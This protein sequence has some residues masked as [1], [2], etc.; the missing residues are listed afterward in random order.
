MEL[1]YQNLHIARFT[2]TLQ[3]E[4]PE[5]HVYSFSDEVDAEEAMAL[6]IAPDARTKMVL[7]RSL[8]RAEALQE[9]ETLE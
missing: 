3:P 4:A 1:H 7:V 9:D 5:V 6:E 8:Q 2:C